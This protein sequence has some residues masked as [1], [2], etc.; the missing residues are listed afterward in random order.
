MEFEYKR[1]ETGDRSP[2]LCLPPTWEPMHATEGAFSE[3]QYIYGPTARKAFESVENP[4]FISVGLGL[5]YN[6][7]LCACESLKNRRPFDL[8]HSYESVTPLIVAFQDWIHSRHSALGD[9][10]EAIVALYANSYGIT[11]GDIRE[12]LRQA[13][14]EGRLILD[15]AITLDTRPPR[16]HGIFFDAFSS[17]TSP[18]LWTPE[19][20]ERF[21]AEASDTPCFLSTY[22]SM[23]NLKRALRKNNFEIQTFKGFGKKREST[24][25]EL[26]YR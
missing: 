20:L 7:M 17:K 4:R 22:A 26:K 10:Y 24:F 8:L 2:S 14:A 1:L 19:F 6:E 9:I 11:G 13:L 21:L 5:G 3:T 12:H 18:E 23:G 15:G 25:A 16:S